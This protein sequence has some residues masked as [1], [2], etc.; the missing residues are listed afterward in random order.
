VERALAAALTAL[1]RKERSVAELD[2]W[3]A[4]RGAPTDERSAVI[5][6]LLELGELDDG[7]FARRFAEDKRDL[8]AWGAERIRETLLAR[9]V[10]D[11]AVEAALAG[12]GEMEQLDQAAEL[13]ERR[14]TGLGDDR[15]R[16]RALSLLTRYGYSYD[17]ARTAIR[18][19][20]RRAA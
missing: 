16:S 7:R 19:V 2:A 17:I 8:S 11:A 15:A 5:E 14:E 3:L 20:E 13:L 12:Y 9:G 1:R 18:Q 4:H 10:D 6:R